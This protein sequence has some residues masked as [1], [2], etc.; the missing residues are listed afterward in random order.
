[1]RAQRIVVVKRGEY[2]REREQNRSSKR[3]GE[4]GIKKKWNEREKGK[5]QQFATAKLYDD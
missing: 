2:Q 5:E 1:M 3:H 4:D